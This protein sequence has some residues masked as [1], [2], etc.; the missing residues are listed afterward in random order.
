MGVKREIE[1]PKLRV[2]HIS[3]HKKQVGR[4]VG[5]HVS[6]VSRGAETRGEEGA[7]EEIIAVLRRMVG[8]D[9]TD[10]KRATIERDILTC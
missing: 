2:E 7:Y 6:P 3:K 4:P 8:V 5:A 10:Y 9:F 1:S